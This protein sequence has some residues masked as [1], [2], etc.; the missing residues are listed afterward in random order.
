M[1]PACVGGSDVGTGVGGALSGW[2]AV[3][4]RRWGLYVGLA[5]TWVVL[6]ALMWM[7]PRSETVGFGGAVSAWQYA[8]NQCVMLVEYLRITF[9]PSGLVFDYGVP[10]ALALGDVGL[11]VVIVA[12]TLVVCIALLRRAPAIGYPV[13]WFFV[14]LAPTSSVV[15]IVTEV[16]AERRVYLASAGLLS[17]AV[18]L[19]Y[20][21][22]RRLWARRAAGD[23]PWR[24]GV[25]GA[26][27]ALVCAAGLSFA[28]VQRNR[29]YRSA[30]AIWTTVTERLPDNPRGHV[31]LG[32]ALAQAGQFEAADAAFARALQLDGDNVDTILARGDMLL[33]WRRT[34]DAIETYEQ[35]LRIEPKL[36]VAE[37]RIAR[38]LSIQREWD[39]AVRRYG[40]AL[41]LKPDY[42]QAHLELAEVLLQKDQPIEAAAHYREVMRLR[43]DW[44]APV[45][46]L[47]WLRATHP[48]ERVRDGAEALQLAEQAGALMPRRSPRLLATLAAAHGSVG[49]FGRAIEAAE[50]ALQMAEVA[51]D[52]RSA[53][54]I[55]E[56][57]QSY[58]AGRAFLSSRQE[59]SMME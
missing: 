30:V 36:A 54:Y 11:E 40:R 50:S 55:R 29:E 5:G 52:A 48:D 16:G 57:L 56:Q 43:P 35:A 24:A 49:E 18:V 25:A 20:A 23:A 12:M 59:S 4:R 28:T 37:L 39:K 34:Y 2:G 6:G 13:A 33:G 31:N 42:A 14:V 27:L 26:V 47:A 21:G 38:A 51:G 7:A 3:L 17:L 15:P 22:L 44:W 10:R 45:L 8:L 32:S 41:A 53:A 58:R 19:A 1:P 46:R 9:W